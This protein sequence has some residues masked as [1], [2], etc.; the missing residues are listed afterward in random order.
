MSALRH[1]VGVAGLDRVHERSR[2]TLDVVRRRILLPLLW[3]AVAL[4]LLPAT[5]LANECP[6]MAITAAPGSFYMFRVP[7]C[8]PFGTNIPAIAQQPSHGT[9]SVDGT[10]SFITYTNNGDAAT[11]D[12][13]AW[14]DDLGEPISVAVTVSSSAPPLVVVNPATTPNGA[15]GSAYSL[16]FN[17]S[18]G[19]GGPYTYVINQGNLPVGITDNA[20]GLISGTPSESGIFTFTETA[21]DSTGH[22]GSRTVTLTITG[23][24]ISVNPS[25][26]S[27]PNA[28][29]NQ[30][31]SKTLVASGG[32]G[33]YTFSV[34]PGTTLP[35]GI[36]LSSSGTL[37]GTPTVPGT[38]NF[39][40]KVQESGGASAQIN[41]SLAVI[42]L[43]SI[44]TASLPNGTVG[45]P[46][47]QTISATGGT[48]PYSFSI[49]AG[50]LPAGLSLSSGGIL[51]GTPTAGGSF[52]FTVRLTD[53]NS[54][55]ATHIYTMAVAA[56]TITLSPTSL[57]AAAQ[58]SGYSQT[59][60]ASGGTPTYTFAVTS[61]SLP[62]GLSLSS[63]GVL[64]GTPSGSGNYNFTV[65]ATDS[66]GGTGPYAGSIV[67]AL[68]VTSTSPV[69]TAG[70]GSANFVQADNTTS[71]PVAVAPGLVLT[72]PGASTAASATVWISSAFVAAEDVLAF[73]NDGSTMGNITAS[74]D[75]STGTLTLTSAGATAS[76]AQWQAALRAVT[77]T[78]TAIVPNTST[79]TVSFVLVDA[80]AATSNTAMRTVTVTAT[81]QSP[82][83][84]TLNT[85]TNYVA[86]TSAAVIDGGITVS[87]Q[88]DTTQ[89]SG[90]VSIGPG[91][92]SG[93]TLTFV[94]T[95]SS[96][97]GNIVASYNAATGVLTLTSSGATASNVQW[98]RA[99]SAVTFSCS[100]NAASGSRMIS[101]AV[102]DGVKTSVPA[103]D[104]VLVLGAPSLTTSTGS[105]NFVA[106]D[107]VP[108]TPVAVDSGITFT[109]GG[110]ATAA[111]ATV[112]ISGGFQTSEDV[113]AFINNGST[114]GNISASYDAANGVLS[115]TS[116][117]ATATIAQWQAALR[118]VTYTDTVLTPNNATRTVSFTAVD[119]G[120]ATSN[121]ATRTVTVTDTDQTPI[122]AT[123]GTTVDYT[124]GA[125]ATTIDGNVQVSDLDNTT[126]SVGIVSISPG[127]QFGDTLLFTNTS[128][129]TFGNIVASYNSATG[130]LT[131][132]SSGATATDVQWANAFSA[133][134]FSSSS[135][136]AGIRTISF[137]VSDG[138]KT[139]VPAIDG[140]NVIVNT[141]PGAPTIG[142]ATAGNAQATV[143]FTPPASNGG[144]VIT[145]Y[146]AISSPG[147]ITAAAATSPITVTGLANGTTYTFTV[148][149]RN[150]VGPSAPSAASNAV[151]PKAPQTIT[152]ANPGTQTFATAPTLVASA[153]SGLTVTFTSV[154]SGVCT[155]TAGGALTFVAT[156]TCTIH[157]DQAGDN[158]FLAA[159]TVAQSFTVNPAAQTIAFTS[160][161]P[162]APIVGG[163]YTAAATA[164]SGL[165]VAF[166]IDAASTAGACALAGSTVS[167]T[168]AGTCLVDANQAGNSNYTAAPQAQQT[169]TIGKAASTTSL[170]SSANPS[171]F[172]HGVTFTAT[173]TPASGGP[174]PTG[175]VDFGD[176]ATVLCAAVALNNGAASCTTSAL[177][178][179]THPIQ[180]SYGGDANSGASSATLTQTV[181]KD[182]TTMTLT[183]TPNPAVAGQTITLTATVLG[184][185]PSGTVTFYDGA[186]VLGTSTLAATSPMSS[187]AT[188]A[189]TTLTTGTHTLSATYVGDDN[190][191]AS[192]SAAISVAVALPPPPAV[193]APL[194]DR[195]A[196]MWLVAAFAFVG[197][198]R[199][200]AGQRR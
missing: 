10:L 33:P 107:N 99:L 21:T 197:W 2:V 179:G 54:S 181:G 189:L 116:P 59:I 166:S 47:N 25:N 162:A 69:I 3:L 93:D 157:A 67:Y 175:A 66:S 24:P 51:S 19:N 16:Q 164:S 86:G 123:A 183:V 6:N 74:Y 154:T 141:V 125:P 100:S 14:Y 196:M 31:Y 188:L 142:T 38:A 96:F 26:G 129:V 94:N 161:P 81:D 97:F 105:A 163:A 70:G 185:P 65:T 152:F 61:G 63:G 190:N 78:D 132:T 18:G 7:A 184:D 15:F 27:L 5:L 127:F 103:T 134:A 200:R 176:G 144:A 45:V 12:S 124:V 56:P 28:P 147:G 91:F 115:L 92:H 194:L 49:T 158:A 34:V 153:S 22:A 29:V 173:V 13:F 149:A 89:A 60:T 174:A 156:G 133:V 80:A 8:S 53:A 76:I 1:G 151:T 40:I 198:Q 62:A 90:T 113:L 159:P 171:L 160:T 140:V 137:A 20:S 199:V 23:G 118:A 191:Q 121:T 130:T 131:L 17:A 57:P 143:T 120:G 50:A 48:T 109:D 42:T 106:G 150:S 71:T 136:S 169:I 72:D 77:Y 155:V 110:S 95:S 168:G 145:G 98:S 87:D 4:G 117:G 177:S 114:M 193:A 139:S 180:A 178:V 41:Y 146:T 44:T 165:T 102:S 35:T 111:S 32:T 37:S 187:V 36:T 101:F 85:T 84:A 39:S 75:S 79:R 82:I 30:A 55:T 108:S 52:P 64:S 83:V 9:V 68:S 148:T 128:S 112:R 135:T 119:G 88:N 58:N 122:V 11:S 46:Y 43:P 195:W 73:T 170:Q 167:F 186:A 172:S 126:Q 104:T 138:T 182:T 192:A